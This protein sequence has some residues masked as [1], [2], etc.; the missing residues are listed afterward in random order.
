MLA[1]STI[2]SWQFSRE[3]AVKKMNRDSYAKWKENERV[4]K[5]RAKC[6]KK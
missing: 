5:E 6:L 3:L 2:M 1:P 4:A